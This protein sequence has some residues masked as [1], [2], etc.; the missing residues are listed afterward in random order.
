[1]KIFVSIILILSCSTQRK[2]ENIAGL[3]RVEIDQK[4]YEK[5]QFFIDKASIHFGRAPASVPK[6][7]T[8]GPKLSNRQIYFLT[9]HQQ[10]QKI[11]NILGKPNNVPSC[12][13]FH[14]LLLKNPMVLADIPK[15]K[16]VK[17]DFE[18]I[19]TNP[20]MAKYYPILALPYDNKIDLFTKLQSKNWEDGHVHMQ[21][22]L[23]HYQ[24]NVE[25]EVAELC[26]KGIS[27]GYYTYQ[28]LVTYFKNNS[29]F[30]KSQEG[31]K[32]LLKVP[33]LANMVIIE[34]IIQQT[35]DIHSTYV[36]EELLLERS[37]TTW[38][39]SYLVN[40]NH[41]QVIS[42]NSIVQD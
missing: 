7:V 30:H 32:A 10:Y 20:Q 28:N 11:N 12:P 17:I 31:L 2:L 42:K 27:P 9:T 18:K 1:M 23:I 33:A 6:V 5:P 14:D 8:E 19:K 39:L 41:K 22:A 35:Y 15:I 4:S 29:G 16:D 26:D 37:N 13:S 25:R 38:F 21:E 24:K 3:E 34:N 40:I 36:Y